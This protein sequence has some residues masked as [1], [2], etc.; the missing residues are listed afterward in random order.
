M[1][2][3][4]PRRHIRESE[5]ALIERMLEGTSFKAQILHDIADLL[6]E[7]MSDGGMGSI[8]FQI[9]QPGRRLFGRQISEA[10]FVDADG[11]AVSVTLNLD[12]DGRLFELDMWKADNSGLGRY[13]TPCDISVRHPDR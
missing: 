4:I 8:R 5:R 12:Q 2:G 6:V 3:A 7:D 10:A 9:D 11:V 1:I 13:P